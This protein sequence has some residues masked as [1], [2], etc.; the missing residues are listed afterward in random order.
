MGTYYHIEW[1]VR[2]MQSN[3][4][5]YVVW[6][7]Q[8]LDGEILVTR[9]YHVLSADEVYPSSAPTS[10][11][12]GWSKGL[13]QMVYDLC[14]W[15]CVLFILE[16]LRFL[17]YCMLLSL[18]S[19]VMFYSFHICLPFWSTPSEKR[20]RCRCVVVLKMS[21]AD[22]QLPTLRGAFDSN[23]LAPGRPIF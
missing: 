19:L 13:I 17:S 1:I 21:A 18:E 14:E 22:W 7:R 4:N 8:L 23:A 5:S 3:L 12:N 15:S 11:P 2:F 16:W 20:C 6:Y 10:P 9:Y